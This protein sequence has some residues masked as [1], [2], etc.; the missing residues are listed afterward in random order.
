MKELETKPEVDY[1]ALLEKLLMKI[2]PVTC[3]HRHG[4]PICKRKLDD[5]CNLQIDIEQEI[6]ML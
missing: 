5:L 6:G 2:N 4:T 3:A 1:K